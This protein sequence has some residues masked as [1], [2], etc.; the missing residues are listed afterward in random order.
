MLSDCKVS[1]AHSA[2]KKLKITKVFARRKIIKIFL[3]NVLC[4]VNRVVPLAV[5]AV[6]EIELLKILFKV[7][8]LLRWRDFQLILIASVSS[9]AAYKCHES[10]V[11]KLKEITNLKKSIKI[12]IRC[13]TASKFCCHISRIIN[14]TWTL[15]GAENLSRDRSCVIVA[16]HQ[17]SL[18]VLGEH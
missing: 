5:C 10:I 17:S 16:N 18:D 9:F 7:L 2:S 13:R 15:R 4:R 12:L 3:C 11:R 6:C 14:L 1:S 8:C